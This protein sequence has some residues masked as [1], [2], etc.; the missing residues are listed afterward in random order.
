MHEVLSSTDKYKVHLPA[1]SREY[2]SCSLPSFRK[3]L[4]EIGGVQHVEKEM[5]KGGKSGKKTQLS[6]ENGRFSY[7]PLAP[8][9]R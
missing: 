5:D 9:K 1:K 4:P 3:C 2:C 6:A 8:N 7:H